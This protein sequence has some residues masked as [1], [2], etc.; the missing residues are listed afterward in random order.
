MKTLLRALTASLCLAL[1]AA[2]ADA[3]KRAKPEAGEQQQPKQESAP[4]SPSIEDYKPF[5]HG[6][7]FTLRQ[8]NGRSPAV[9]VWLRVDATGRA[10]GFSG[11]KNF[12]AIF[13]VGAERLGPRAQPAIT[14][15]QC[16]PAAQ[17]L[18]RD[19]WSIMATGPYWKLQGD[20]LIIKGLKG[21]EMQLSRSML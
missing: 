13:V 14:D 3:K 2:P 6:L 9:E 18:E 17:A 10:S 12:S 8:I 15:R 1:L 21:G 11:C 20:T 16:D 5:P 7:V 4:S 19:F